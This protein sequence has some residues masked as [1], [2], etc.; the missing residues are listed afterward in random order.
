MEFATGFQ[1]QHSTKFSHPTKFIC[2]PETFHFAAEKK[3]K[4]RPSLG[5]IKFFSK[6]DMF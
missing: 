2:Q 5:K 3:K 4:K 6:L 1:S